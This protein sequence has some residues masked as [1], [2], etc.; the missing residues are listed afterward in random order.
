MTHPKNRYQGF[1]PFEQL[2]LDNPSLKSFLRRNPKGDLTIDFSNEH[3]VYALNKALLYHYYGYDWDMPKGFLIPPIPG[4]SDYIHALYDLLEES[5][6]LKP[7]IK[8]LDIGCGA[9]CIFPLIGYG[10]YKWQFVG[11]D[12]NPIA[13][14]NADQ[15]IQKN[16]LE[17]VIKLRL[18]N[19]KNHIFSSVIQDSD[20]FDITLCNPPFHESSKQAHLAMK[21]KWKN[22]GLRGKGLNFGGSSHELWCDGGEL[23][24]ITQMI[25]ESKTVNATWFTCLVS[26]QENLKNLYEVLKKVEAT[27]IKQ[28]DMDI[29]NKKTR[30][31]AWSFKRLY[32]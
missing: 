28:I 11:T 15:I 8:A 3:A 31:L 1:Y 29:G 26:K 16:H 30:L 24:F 17:E 23:Y 12:I 6:M 18:Q 22:L 10:E 21:Q 32:L 19:D 2:V 7:S 13:L 9:S 14:K 5:K 20:M 4:R 27:H 25:K